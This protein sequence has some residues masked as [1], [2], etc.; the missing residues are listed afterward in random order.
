MTTT[1]IIALSELTDGSATLVTVE[2]R[3]LCAVRLGDRVL[4]VDD[5]CSHATASLSEG[6]VDEDDCTIECPLHGSLFSLETG[7]AL[8][9]P[10]T[11]PVAAHP[12]TI[13]GGEVFVDLPAAP[14]A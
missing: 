12:V 8:T 3:P 5:T 1:R 7:E 6:D 10:A 9:L 2:G 13:D 11:R 4:V 14:L